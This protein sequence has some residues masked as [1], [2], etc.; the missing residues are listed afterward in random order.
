M[1]ADGRR[2]GKEAKRVSRGSGVFVYSRIRLFC[3]VLFCFCSLC[4]VQQRINRERAT[5]RNLKHSES[6]YLPTSSHPNPELPDDGR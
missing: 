2:S 4:R 3:F 5:S 6:I 1:R